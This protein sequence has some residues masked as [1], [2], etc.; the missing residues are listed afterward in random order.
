MAWGWNMPTVSE[1]EKDWKSF[2]NN[3]NMYI[4]NALNCEFRTKGCLV[5][6]GWRCVRGKKWT[7]TKDMGGKWCIDHKIMGCRSRFGKWGGFGRRIG[8][9]SRIWRSWDS[10]LRFC[11]RWFWR[12]NEKIWEVWGVTGS[13][14]LLI[15]VEMEEE[16]EKV[17]ICVE[18]TTESRNVGQ[19]CNKDTI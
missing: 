17:N 9:A 16:P 18:N 19:V 4:P 14:G 11:S 15:T 3:T 12:H 8:L 6:L 5:D 13:Q 10:W 2:S 1:T 7:I